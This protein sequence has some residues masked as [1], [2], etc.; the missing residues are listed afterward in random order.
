M[1]RLPKHLKG[2]VHG[3]QAF[4]KF[5]VQANGGLGFELAAQ[6][7]TDATK[8]VLLGSRSAEKGEAAV[9]E[10]QSRK[11]PGTIELVQIDVSNQAS[12]EA[13]AKSVESKHGK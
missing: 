12:I 2:H 6:L 11:Q 3:N 10:L 1:V 4:A 7:I 8:Y 13:A 5:V 9:T